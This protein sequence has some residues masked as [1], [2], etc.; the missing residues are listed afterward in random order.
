MR[1]EAGAG[2]GGAMVILLAAALLAAPADVAARGRRGASAVADK[3]PSEARRGT[4]VVLRPGASSSRD[5]TP[6]EAAE[7]APAGRVRAVLPGPAAGA[8]ADPEE[9]AR[10]AA[11][12]AS[13]E[14]ALGERA[15]AR[16][17]EAEHAE[18]LRQAEARLAA[19]RA[20]EE[21][22][23]A[24]RQAAALEQHKRAQATQDAEVEQVLE[25]AKNDHPL[26]R[27]PEGEPILRS[28]LQRQQVLRARGVYPSIAMV[29]AV[30][31]HSGALRPRVRT[32]PDVTPAPLG[33]PDH[34]KTY[35][36]CRWVTP[37]T[38]SCK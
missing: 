3:A 34:S 1:N 37:Y 12:V 2:V 16:Q 31:D 26:L 13:F 25:R 18:A 22:S 27:T 23:E 24:A 11:A 32:T 6:T 15:A 30:A 38:W 19:Q 33:E 9:Q 17:A 5:G 21:R 7:P 35:G 28:I 20:A 4:H 29:E 14:R 10:R 8:D 36:N